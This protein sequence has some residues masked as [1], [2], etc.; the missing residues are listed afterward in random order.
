ML[1]IQF[2]NSTTDTWKKYY[3]DMVVEYIRKFGEAARGDIDTLL[4]S[5]L[6]DILSVNQKKNKVAG[7]AN[8]YH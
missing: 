2:Q 4:F 8:F 7:R 3:K 1:F 5:K 6:P